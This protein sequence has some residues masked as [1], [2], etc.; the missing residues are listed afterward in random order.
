MLEYGRF[1]QNQA[2]SF[3]DIQTQNKQIQFQ[4][5]NQQPRNIQVMSFLKNLQGFVS[6]YNINEVAAARERFNSDPILSQRNTLFE[7]HENQQMNSQTQYS[8]KSS[9][10]KY[11][12]NQ[13][14]YAGTG[15]QALNVNLGSN[16]HLHMASMNCNLKRMLQRGIKLSLEVFDES[17]QKLVID[18]N[19]RIID[20]KMS[21]Y[22]A[23][24]EYL[25]NKGKQP[26]LEMPRLK[27]KRLRIFVDIT[28]QKSESKTNTKF[29]H[30]KYLKSQ[31][32][33]L[34]NSKNFSNLIS[35]TISKQK[36]IRK[37]SDIKCY[38]YPLN[39][40]TSQIFNS[41]SKKYVSKFT[42]LGDEDFFEV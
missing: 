32:S 6:T 41:Q 4:E 13:Y 1:T 39:T 35:M 37:F 10:V 21:E 17:D 14:I 20:Q 11:E 27:Q 38:Q 3:Q 23:N 15:S 29:A 9:P 7:I 19:I 42:Q 26:K 2:F 33:E 36:C 31:Q 40:Q 8:N 22:L 34:L 18:E 5:F 28:N 12:E 16:V 24:K 30:N 25:L